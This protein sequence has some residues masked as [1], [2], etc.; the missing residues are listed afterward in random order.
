M[1]VM[2]IADK[3]AIFSIRFFLCFRIKALLQP[4]QPMFI[5]CPSFGVVIKS[6]I[7][8]NTYRNPLSEQTF[9]FK[10]DEWRNTTSIS[11]N[12]LCYC[13]PFLMSRLC[14]KLL[15]NPCINNNTLCFF[16]TDCKPSF[17]HIVYIFLLD[18]KLHQ[19]LFQIIKRSCNHLKDESLSQL[20]SKEYNQIPESLK[21]FCMNRCIHFLPILP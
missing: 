13:D 18:I 17:I 12:T 21:Y 15:M 1:T 11:T 4:V 3:N 10:S 19:N 8:I 7:T 6:P 14:L 9:S 5:A 16:F 20:A 2:S